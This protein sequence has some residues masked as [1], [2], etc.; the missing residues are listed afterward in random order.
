MKRIAIIAAL[1]VF[2]ASAALASDLPKKVKKKA[3]AAPVAAAPGA[4]AKAAAAPASAP[5]TN[6]ISIEIGPEMWANVDGYNHAKSA[7]PASNGDIRDWVGKIGYS[8]T[9]E[10]NWIVGASVSH[11]AAFTQAAVGDNASA[12]APDAKTLSKTALEASVAY[13]Y[14]LIDS[15]TLTPAAGLGY[16]WGWV[17]MDNPSQDALK[18][19]YSDPGTFGTNANSTCKSDPTP[20]VQDAAGNS[21]SCYTP[22]AYYFLT[23]AGDWKIDSNWTWNVFNI[24]YR[25]SFQGNWNTPKIATGVT[26]NISPEDAIYVSAGLAFKNP[27]SHSLQVSNDYEDVT[28]I[29]LGYKHA[30]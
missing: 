29:T 27:Y 22:E 8:H 9:F 6:S 4:P 16:A 28:N 24:R 2:A 14:K 5:K 18:S 10:G 11:T 7:N 20:G 15:F 23:L 19:G 21:L 25:D 1:S 13:K 3:P 12:T 26:Y 30:F 17:K